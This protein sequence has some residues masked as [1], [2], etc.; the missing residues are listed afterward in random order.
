MSDYFCLSDAELLQKV[1]EGEYLAEE[2]LI[3][4]YSRLVRSRTRKF[5]LL[6]GNQDDLLQ[7]GMLGL[8]S[9]IR[10]YKQENSVSFQSYA[11]V[12]IRNRIQSAVRSSNR[13]KNDPLNN[14]VSFDQVLSHE[15]RTP[16]VFERSPEEKVLAKESETDAVSFYNDLLSVFEAK[17]LADYLEGFSYTEISERLRRPVKSVDNAVQR[18]RRKLALFLRR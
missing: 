14:A 8:L 3:Y 12:C 18:I 1:R 16:P 4:R 9:A 15:S 13:K 6:D 11:D 10:N 17:V 5:F 7:E 2:A